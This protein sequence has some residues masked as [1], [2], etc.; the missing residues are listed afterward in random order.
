M[1][2]DLKALPNHCNLL[3]IVVITCHPRM[4][5][6]TNFLFANLAAANI[7]VCL[8]NIVPTLYLVVWNQSL[9]VGTWCPLTMFVMGLSYCASSLILMALSGERYIAIVHSMKY[10]QILTKRRIWV[11]TITAWL[12]SGAY[13]S[14][15]LFIY[16]DFERLNAVNYTVKH[17]CAIDATRLGAGFHVLAFDV[18]EVV[19]WFLLPSV[20]LS[21]V[22][23]KIC[24]TLW[25]S[26]KSIQHN[27]DLRRQSRATEVPLVNGKL[28]IGA[29]ESGLAGDTS[30]RR[31]SINGDAR[32]QVFA[33]SLGDHDDD[34]DNE[35]SPTARRSSDPPFLAVPQSVT[36]LQQRRF[37]LSTAL[38]GSMQNLAAWRRE[39]DVSAAFL[40]RSEKSVLD[41]RK[42]IIK[43]LIAVILSLILLS[44]PYRVYG[45]MIHW[46]A[47]ATMSLFV[48]VAFL[49]LYMINVVIPGLLF[50]TS[51]IFRKAL[52][53]LLTGKAGPRS[54][55]RRK[56]MVVPVVTL[57]DA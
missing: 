28:T 12:I 19:L 27:S 23:G 30:P 50:G 38:R 53:E 22:C 46:Y 10:K 2:A 8:F 49:L 57:N 9:M 15:Y 47:V 41:V 54:H 7:S 34:D 44:L 21:V 1:F 6:I 20:F 31:A 43:M 52:V 51:A 26:Q 35:P 25:R 39:S 4:R 33:P 40:T 42:R 16:R 48:R 13:S 29:A 18:A 17:Y 32:L 56:Q 11:I 37:S 5:T 14:T 3:V 55:R 36:P 45:L 24:I